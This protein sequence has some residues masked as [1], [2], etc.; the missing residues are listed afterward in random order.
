VA[1]SIALDHLEGGFGSVTEELGGS[2]LYFALAA[3]LIAPVAIVAP[4]G[5]DAVD[6]VREVVGRR[7]VDLGGLAVV[8]APTYRWH[9]RQQGGRN[10]DLGSRDSIYDHWRPAL[11][12]GYKGWAFVG[13]MRPDRQVEAASQA[14]AAGLLAADAMRS[15]VEAAPTPAR[16]LLELSSWYFCNREEFLA[17]GGDPE[18]PERFRADWKLEG[19]VLKLGPEGLTAY[20]DGSEH[21]L[22]ALMSHPVIDTTGAGDALAGGMLARWLQ[23]GGRPASLEDALAFGIACASIAIEDVGLRALWAA[24]PTRLDERVAEV[25]ALSR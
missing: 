7:P 10:F 20:V 19:L 16:R 1:G 15:Y 3:S 6:R 4:V 17:L 12:D 14:S 23:T 21:A 24:T 13:S 18:Q 9:A 8:D 25:R 5:E 2:A 11:P 22:P